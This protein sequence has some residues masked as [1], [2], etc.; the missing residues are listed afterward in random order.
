[1]AA[2]ANTHDQLRPSI[3]SLP[4]GSPV[5]TGAQLARLFGI[6]PR[7]VARVLATLKSE[8]CI[9]RIRGKGSYR[10]PLQKHGELPAPPVPPVE[11]LVRVFADALGRGEFVAG[12]ALPPVK[13]LVARF[14]VRGSTVTAACREL[15]TRGLATRVGR[16][17]LAGHPSQLLKAAAGKPVAFFGTPPSDPGSVFGDPRLARAYA[18]MEGELAD[19]GYRIRYHALDEFAAQAG[20]WKRGG[21]VPYA[22]VVAGVSSRYGTYRDAAVDALESRPGSSLR[23]LVQGQVEPHRAARLFL[24]SDGNINTRLCRETARFVVEQHRRHVRVFVDTRIARPFRAVTSVKLWSE[25]L[26]LGFAGTFR[27]LVRTSGI[28]DRRELFGRLQHT[29]QSGKERVH[30]RKYEQA[31]SVEP[32]KLVELTRSA[33]GALDTCNEAGVLWVTWRAAEA[34]QLHEATCARRRAVP[35]HTALLSLENDPVLYQPGISSCDLDSERMGY[36]MAHALIGDLPVHRTGKGFLEPQV[37]LRH[38]HTTIA[39]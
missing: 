11:A 4:A 19:H 21:D 17:Y 34:L 16:T 39:W 27:I 31:P 28:A 10:A 14:H 35:K 30:L 33:G 23:V 26:H 7:T 15:V 13:Y 18:R 24:L 36:T 5:P 25:L 3:L 37:A 22:A 2:A 8:G 9:V 38:R 29:A 6:S 12:S 1:M 20:R 32:H